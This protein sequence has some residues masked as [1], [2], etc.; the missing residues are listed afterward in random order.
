[1]NALKLPLR[2]GTSWQPLNTSPSVHILSMK[3]VED[4]RSAVT[5]VIHSFLEADWTACGL[6]EV[7]SA[8]SCLSLWMRF[9][10]C[11]RGASLAAIH[12]LKAV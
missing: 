8:R 3:L 12:V 7:K 9:V 2:S 1:M 10:E 5:V 6:L 4:V 11:S